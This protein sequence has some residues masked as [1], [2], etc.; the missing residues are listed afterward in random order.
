[1]SP[2]DYLFKIISIKENKK[3]IFSYFRQFPTCIYVHIELNQNT[4]ISI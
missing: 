2:N 3:T 1:M 4:S